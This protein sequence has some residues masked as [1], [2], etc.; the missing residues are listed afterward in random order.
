MDSYLTPYIPV[1]ILLVL[2][3]V[4]CTLISFLAG[5]LGPKRT[6]TSCRFSASVAEPVSSRPPR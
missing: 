4:M 5:F 6:R 3:G 2:A 1:L